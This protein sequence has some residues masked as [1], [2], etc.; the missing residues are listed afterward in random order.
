MMKR[1]CKK[2]VLSVLLA[3]AFAGIVSSWPTAGFGQE[4]QQRQDT[5]AKYEI[6]LNRNIFS[7]QRGPRRQREVR[8]EVPKEVPNPESFYRLKGVVQEDGRF[9]AFIEDTRS[10]QI[11]RLQ[12]GEPVAR[13]V[14]KSLTLDSIEYEFEGRVALVKVGLDLEGGLGAVTQTELMQWSPSQ[15]DQP[16]TSPEPA[17]GDQAD[18]L[19]QMMERRRQ[20]L[21]Q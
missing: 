21:G 9:T 20:Q 8:E 10:S 4:G 7:R 14:V 19:R 5:W 17:A 15:T 6:I 12:Q 16:G 11:L 3:M 1:Y 13:G 18:I 2:W